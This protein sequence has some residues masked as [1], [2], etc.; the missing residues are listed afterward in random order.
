LCYAFWSETMQEYSESQK[1]GV[2]K[3]FVFQIFRIKIL[4]NFCF[5][6]LFDL[7]A[8]REAGVDPNMLVQIQILELNYEIDP[9]LN[10]IIRRF[11]FMLFFTWPPWGA[12]APQVKGVK[13]KFWILAIF[14]KNRPLLKLDILNY[15][16]L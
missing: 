13:H 2:F 12:R 8:P 10:S 6:L 9:S 15:A 4:G 1:F 16:I 14:N 5:C 11:Y 7:R 3:N